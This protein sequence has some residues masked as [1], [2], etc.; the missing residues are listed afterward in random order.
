VTN[1]ADFA[2]RA[3]FPRS[4][5]EVVKA[6][7]ERYGAATSRS[8]SMPEYVIAGGQRC[9]TTSLYQY[10]VEHPAVGAAT[11]KE[12]HYFDVSYGRGIDWYRGHFPTSAYLRAVS[13]RTGMRATTGEASPYYLFHPRAPYRLADMLPDAKLIVMLRDPVSRMISHYHH[14][15]AFGHEDQSLRRAVELEA[16]RLAGEEARILHDPTYQSYAHQHH[17]YFAR[18]IYVDQ[19]ERWFSALPRER[20]LILESRRFFQNPTDELDRVLGFLGLPPQRRTE[21]E[22]H[23]TR[24]YAPVEKGLQAELYDRFAPHNERLYALLGEDYGWK[25][26]T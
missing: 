5:K 16:D 26:K 3:R 1:L 13:R 2:L 17:S 14:E 10:L 21:F 4:M 8:R 7:V 23:N 25:M 18:G 11:T 12:V 20:F 22:A 6:G 24:A 15:V 9:G 19:L